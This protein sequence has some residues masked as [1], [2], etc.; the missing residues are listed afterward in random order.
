MNCLNNLL[1]EGGAGAGTRAEIRAETSLRPGIGLQD[2]AGDVLP[3]KRPS[4]EPGFLA[5]SSSIRSIE[6]RFQQGKQQEQEPPGAILV[7][8]LKLDR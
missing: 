8:N 6:R 1:E 4:T 2:G 3:E 5:S 7:D